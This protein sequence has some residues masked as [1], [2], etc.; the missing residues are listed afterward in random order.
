MARLCVIPARGAS[1]RIPRKNIRLFRGQPMIAWSIQAALASGCFDEIIVSTDDSEIAAVAQECGASVPFLRPA[2]LADDFVG[3]T[4][5]VIHAIEQLICQGVRP[6]LVCCLYA[7]APFVRPEDLR[8]GYAL[9]LAQEPSHPVFTAATYPF[10]I[11][12][13]FVISD[14]G[15]AEMLQPACYHMRSQ[16]LPEA[17]HD[18][19]QFYWA[20][21]IQ[22][23]A[24]PQF[25]LGS[26]P[27]I[28]P[29][30]RVQDIDTE[31]DWRHAELLH[32]LLDDLCQ[33]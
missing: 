32:Q 14:D 25:A 2:T 11:Q 3:T 12:R 19:G 27:L 23:L 22:W 29:R 30:W 6:S 10:P 21:R 31:E 16:D 24:R 1:K 15:V 13:G 7:T 5:V 26:V 4:D 17:Y 18:A 28:L 33:N 9:W 8:S 20:N